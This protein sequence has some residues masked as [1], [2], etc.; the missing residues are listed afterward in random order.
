MNKINIKRK[1]YFGFFD[2]RLLKKNFCPKCG[3]K[4]K[5][6]ILTYRKMKEKKILKIY[7]TY[8]NV[9]Y[10][11]EKCDFYIDFNKQKHISQLQNQAEKNILSNADAL[12]NNNKVQIIR[13]DNYYIL[14][15]NVI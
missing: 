11:C 12:I 15:N 5:L 14:K 7:N 1:N 9:Y 10:F 13:K 2:F 8:T 3:R 4:Y 6:K